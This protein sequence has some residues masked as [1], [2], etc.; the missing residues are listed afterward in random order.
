M[1]G[2]RYQLDLPSRV[3]RT[4]AYLL[5]QNVP[6]LEDHLTKKINFCL[7]KDPRYQIRPNFASCSLPLAARQPHRPPLRRHS[8]Y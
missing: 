6:I 2:S 7:C 1:V 4:D 5:P 8:Q 3:P